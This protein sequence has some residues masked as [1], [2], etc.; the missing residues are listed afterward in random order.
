LISTNCHPSAHS[1]ASGNPSH[2]CK[3]EYAAL[4]PRLRGDER[5]SCTERTSAQKRA[6]EPSHIA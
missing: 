3:P 4:D 6:A 5:A 2:D 1:R